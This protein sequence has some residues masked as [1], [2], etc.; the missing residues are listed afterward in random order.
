V[1]RLF[2]AWT[3]LWA[4]LLSL[5]LWRAGYAFH[6]FGFRPIW[7]FI[8]EVG[9]WCGIMGSAAILVS[10]LYSL[11]QW[12]WFRR[13]PK[14][15]WLQSHIF[16]GLVGPVLIE[17]HGYG[18][19]YGLAGWAAILMW[20]VALS[21]FIGL[22][23]RGYLADD[24][25]SRQTEAL[26]LQSRTEALH[27][28]LA[29]H[30]VELL[31]VQE[32]IAQACVRTG[33]AEHERQFERG[34]V[35]RNPRTALRL[36]RD[37]LAYLSQV[38]QLRRKFRRSLSQERRLNRLASRQALL[39]LDLETRARTSGIMDDLFALWRLIHTPLTIAFV[40]TVLT[41]FWAIWRY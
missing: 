7:Q 40:I 29:E 14:P 38:R 25:R 19:D 33:V 9:F 30:R 8:Q 21:G 18:K 26:E 1:T 5:V 31:D 39:S 13:C 34:R 41:H 11:R 20:A 35:S 4:T 27:F 15:L 17:I 2:N 24:I 10:I 28:Q 12:R 16:F 3:G 6:F 37:Y 22:Y 32:Q 23:L 36:I